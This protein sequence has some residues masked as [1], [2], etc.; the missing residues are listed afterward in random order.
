MEPAVVGSAAGAVGHS[1]DMWSLFMMADWVVKSVMIGLVVASVWC[2]AIIFDK[3]MRLSSVRRSANVFE[4]TF[5]NAQ[6]L[7][8]LYDAVSTR[9]SNPMTALF[10]GAMRE[11]KRSATVGLGDH[12]AVGIKERLNRVVDITITREMD[13]LESQMTV[14]A[15]VGSVSPFVG[16]FGTVWGI[17]NSFQS[18]AASENTSLVVVAPGI[19]EALFATALGLAAAIPA[20]LAYNKFNSD[21]SRYA[22]RL[23]SFGGELTA[24]LSRKLDERG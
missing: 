7:D 22:G 19:A 9:P 8:E 1:M 13:R 3:V 18:I 21:L 11:W 24:L 20:V 15:S 17:M 6:S 14:L 4:D 5:W 23:E 2:W 10:V 12:T 16:L